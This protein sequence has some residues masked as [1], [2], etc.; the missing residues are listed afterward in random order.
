MTFSQLQLRCIVCH[1]PFDFGRE[2]AVVLRHIAYGFDFVHSRHE[3]TAL[4]WIFVDPQYDR[5]EFTHDERRVRVL[6]VA[7]AANWAAV[8]PARPEQIA[9]GNPFTLQPVGLWALVEYCDGSQHLEGLVRE[10]EWE[11]EPGGTEFL[12]RNG[13]PRDVVGYSQMEEHLDYAGIACWQAAIYARN[14][15]ERFPLCRNV[16]L[17][18]LGSAALPL[19]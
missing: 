15:G 4:D 6:A 19:D 10:S 1:E 12:E 7:P 3:S 11:A 14:R 5:P 17:P 18:E 2:T 8:M 9:T 13:G 16:S